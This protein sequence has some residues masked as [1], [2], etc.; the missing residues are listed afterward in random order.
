MKESEKQDQNLRQIIFLII[1]CLLFLFIAKQLLFMLSAFLGAVSLYVILRIPHKKL[2]RKYKIARSK[3]TVILLLLSA[4]LILLPIY[5]IGNFLSLK[6]IPYFNEPKP[7]VDALHAI[8]AYI[9]QYIE[10]SIL[11]SAT[12]NKIGGIVQAFAP[13][14]INYSLNLLS[15]T[16]IMYFLLWFML[17]KGFEM[18]R[19]LKA[20]SPFNRI[21][22]R[23]VIEHIKTSIFRWRRHFN[24]RTDTRNSCNYWL[25]Y[26]WIRRTNTLGINY[27]CGI[28]NSFCWHYAG[29][30]STF[31][32]LDGK[33]TFELWNRFVSVWSLNYRQ[34]RQCI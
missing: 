6:I 3:S 8:N 5:L 9:N 10:F 16:I 4:I 19:F 13:G 18:E 30:G 24:L 27:W 26:F 22:H 15:N 20:N 11:S 32:T 2:Q 14:L 31:H 34:Q 1:V 23:K 33:W 28:C 17:N 7:I 12:L 21:N 29:V 25:L